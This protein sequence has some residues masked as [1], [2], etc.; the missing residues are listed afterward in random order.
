MSET[1]GI[2][3]F[4]AILCILF[5]IGFSVYG[6]SKL[7]EYIDC[8]FLKQNLESFLKPNSATMEKVIIKA[9]PMYVAAF[10]E[11]EIRLNG[12]IE[13]AMHLS[14]IEEVG[15]VINVLNEIGYSVV[16]EK[17]NPKKL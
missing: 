15:S 4:T 2:A 14:S 10:S 8:K 13:N 6:D 11:T 16:I 12:A 5:S 3:L 1:I 17:V 9:G 7:K